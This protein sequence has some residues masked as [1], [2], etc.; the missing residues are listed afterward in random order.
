MLKIG[1]TFLCACVIAAAET[2]NLT[3]QQALAIAMRQNPDV[4][5]TRLDQQRTKD[6]IRIAQ[7]PFH[8]KVYGGSGLAYTYGYPNS[9]DGNAPSLFQVKTDMALFN[10]PDTYKISSAR[11]FAHGA[12][13]GAEAKAEVVAYQTADLFLSA[14]QTEHESE[15]LGNEI[16]GL[17]K[18]ATAMEAAVQEGSE[19]PL[20][21]KR[22]EVNLA[23]SQQRLDA[24]ALDADYYEMMLAIVLGFPATD[25]V[26]PVDSEMPEMATPASESDASDIALRN[27]GELKQM[28]ANVLAKELDMRSYRAERLPKVDAVLQYSLFLKENYQEY[29]QKFQHNNA[30]IGASITI[31]LLIGPQAKAL[32]DQAAIDMAK[33]RIQMEQVRNR[34]I[35]DT[36]RS[37]QQWQKAASIRDL[38][39]MQLDLARENLTVLLAQNGEGRVPLRAVE[40][41]RLE[42][43]DKWIALFEAETQLTRTKIAILRQMGTLVA[44]LRG[45]DAP[46]TP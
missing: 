3:L 8:P 30:Q 7:N 32:A 40:Q 15:T 22:A 16:P 26:K 34:I 25:R 1:L 37:Y 11:E 41:A 27:N 20:E 5:L 10:R 38:T 35:S 33:L 45:T 14:S 6:D 28:R 9:I 23:I 44:S 24:A 2:H 36:R 13:F 18:V 21:R 29:F 46:A 19:L 39:R 43:N 31:P 12:Q 17:K 42:E 4:M